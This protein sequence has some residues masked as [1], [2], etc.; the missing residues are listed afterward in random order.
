MMSV[1]T[2]PSTFVTFSRPKQTTTTDT[3]PMT[4]VPTQTGAPRYWLTVAPLPANMMSVL[5]PM[6]IVQKMSRIFPSTPPQ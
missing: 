6:A 5:R 2:K 1:P 3:T 4:S